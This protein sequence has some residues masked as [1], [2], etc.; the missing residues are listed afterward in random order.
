MT[1]KKLSIYVI[2]SVLIPGLYLILAFYLIDMILPHIQHTFLYLHIDLI[3]VVLLIVLVINAWLFVPLVVNFKADYDL[4]VKLSKYLA[5]FSL[6]YAILVKIVLYVLTFMVTI[7]VQWSVL[8]S[9]LY[10]MPLFAILLS[11]ILYTDFYKKSGKI[12]SFLTLF[13][14]IMLV[15]FSFFSLASAISV[16]FWL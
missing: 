15:S 11:L 3:F 6:F 8:I 7:H 9:W 10:T 4:R 13:F 14:S 5:I 2:G 16:A 1:S 12:S